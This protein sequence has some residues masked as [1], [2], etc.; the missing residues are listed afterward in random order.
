MGEVLVIWVIELKDFQE[1]GWY[2]KKKRLK[3]C[4]KCDK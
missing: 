3:L 4:E 1:H 2:K